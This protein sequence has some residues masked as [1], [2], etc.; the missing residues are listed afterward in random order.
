M[1]GLDQPMEVESQVVAKSDSGFDR[2][3]SGVRHDETSTG[4][5]TCTVSE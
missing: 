4:Y 2:R 3:K 5:E 1:G